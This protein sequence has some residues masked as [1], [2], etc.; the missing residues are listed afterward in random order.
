[1]FFPRLDA[2][3]RQDRDDVLTLKKGSQRLKK[4]KLNADLKDKLGDD[5]FLDYRIKQREKERRR[6]G[7][8]AR[9]RH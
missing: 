6:D 8:I 4:A 2:V 5:G 3:T 7:A 9:R 1:M